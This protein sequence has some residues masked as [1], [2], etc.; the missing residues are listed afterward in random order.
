LQ[1]LVELTQRDPGSPAFVDLGNA[2]IAL[3]RPQ[4]AVEVGARGL[5]ASPHITAGRLMVSEAFV[6]MHRWKEAQVELLK[7]VK[8]DR[9]NMRG[10]TLLGEVLM[11]RADYE[12]ALPVLQHAQNLDPHNPRLQDL[13]Y[14]AHNRLSLDP[15]PPLPRPMAPAAGPPG[16]AAPYGGGGDFD[17]GL[18]TRVAGPL[19]GQMAQMGNPQMGNPQMSNPMGGHNAPTMGLSVDQASLGA[20]PPPSGFGQPPPQ[21][22]ASYGQPAPASY[23][24]PAPASYG[25][26][27]P[28]SAAPPMKEEPPKKKKKHVQ[29]PP[30]GAPMPRPRVMPA[31]KPRDA[32][33]ESLRQSAAVGEDYLNNL[34]M[35]GL[36]DMPSVNAPEAAF[37][38]AP[39]KRWGRSTR[40]AFV[41][42]FIMLFASLGGGGYWYYYAATQRDAKV[43]R[44]I[45]AARQLME[46]GAYD[47][48][49]AAIKETQQAL[50]QDPESRL[51]MAVFTKAVSLKVLLY[52]PQNKDADRADIAITRTLED[53][54][55]GD[56]GWGDLMI[57]RS[58]L[59]L[60]TLFYLEEPKNQLADTRKQLD[61]LLAKPDQDIEARDQQWARW[62]TGK[63]LQAAGDYDGAL[64]AFEQA[65]AGGEGPVVATVS[66]ADMYLDRSQ[67][68][69][70]GER[71]DAAL[72][73]TPKHPLALI[74]KVL[75]LSE[76]TADP[77]AIAG[78]INV[79]FDKDKD[80][81][82]NVEAYK[83]LV[84]AMSS[85]L[86][87][88][89]APFAENL[90]KAVGVTEPRYLARV[91]Y[92][93]LLQGEVGKAVELRAQIKWYGDEDPESP[94][95]L[96]ALLDAEL[97]L[98]RGSPD[99]A[100]SRLEKLEGVRAMRLRGRAYYDRGDPAKAIEE[101]EKVLE[102]APDDL[103][104]LAW[105]GAARLVAAE[106]KKD[107]D[108]AD[109]ALN[110]LGRAYLNLMVGTIHGDALMRIGK[111]DDARRK[112]E[113]SLEEMSNEHVNPLAYRAHVGLA[114]L[115]FAAGKYKGAIEELDKAA[116]QVADYLPAQA[117]IGRIF[118]AK[119]DYDEAA[120]RLG[121][122]L[123]ELSASA[124]FDIE[125]AYAEAVASKRKASAEERDKALAAVTRAKDKGAPVEELTRV[126]Q[127]L[128]PALL[129]QLGLA[130]AAPPPKKKRGK[131]RRR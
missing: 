85:Y 18:P 67:T 73:R 97:M 4:E 34:L 5:Q 14:R 110:K 53:M 113:T 8:A 128:D 1:E 82:P 98:L 2:Y 70:A 16:H 22:P 33:H 42:L 7:V 91:A 63:A 88:E 90:D 100:L 57:A 62:L 47:D 3:G 106:S 121:A 61:K 116:E 65:E 39:G 84:L 54:D 120:S 112:L 107:I 35:A 129:E 17:D 96:V 15:P 92:D 68:S 30:P 109:R 43:S 77:A 74:G 52:G 102:I 38:L 48:L 104:V 114:Q 37:E 126:A 95:P 123:D 23:G 101:L 130:A 58:A 89:Y 29:P 105:V 83:I 31:E 86:L 44:H 13:A 21:A 11:R 76:T 125:L 71:Y 46:S 93:R 59:T 87:E 81:G 118:L 115:E 69:K 24:Q 122:V 78:A 99:D 10:F 55:E 127:L 12:R 45:A 111:S 41:F 103:R 50:E 94:P 79:G 51:S 6:Q 26:P 40:R 28:A 19:A 49:L 131:K 36:L 64:Q 60:A 9:N 72:Q 32:A 66:A 75:L 25:Q 27:A 124:Q 20:P 80:Y 117:L 108:E 56:E 119:K